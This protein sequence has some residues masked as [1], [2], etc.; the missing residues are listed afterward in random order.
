MT[1]D[2]NF[3]KYISKNFI[4]SGTYHGSGCINAIKSGF[5]NIYSIELLPE[6]HDISTKNINK[7]I[8]DNNI[9][10]NI[11]LLIGNSITVLP[12]LLD[13]INNKCTF[14]LDGHDYGLDVKGCPLYEE[15]DTISKHRIKDHIIL[16]DDLRIIRKDAWGTKNINLKTIIDKIMTINPNYRISYE[17]GYIE[18]DVLVAMVQ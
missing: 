18:N 10:I 9:D 14:W 11:E 16:I 5:Q 7:F 15:I 2:F 4:E 6:N 8:C 17:N 3:N 1:A 12:K 13:K